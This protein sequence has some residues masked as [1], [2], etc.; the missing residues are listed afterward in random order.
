MIGNRSGTFPYSLA[1]TTHTQVL[2]ATL[3]SSRSKLPI[4]IAI[5]AV[6]LIG[7]VGFAA[8]SWKDLR[9][10]D[11]VKADEVAKQE[12]SRSVYEDYG[13]KAIAFVNESCRANAVG[14][15][16]TKAVWKAVPVLIGLRT[17]G[18]YS[19]AAHGAYFDEGSKTLKVQLVADVDG[20]QVKAV[21]VVAGQPGSFTIVRIEPGTIG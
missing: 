4:W 21:A 9:Q 15:T 14:P 16:N 17:D 20:K 11:L 10:A 6:L 1:M 8:W 12:V 5:G 2:P 19:G 18:G 13:P 7:G 3:K